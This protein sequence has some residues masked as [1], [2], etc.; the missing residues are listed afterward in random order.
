[1][2]LALVDEAVD[3]GDALVGLALVVEQDDLDLLA[4]DA[5]GGVD[6][7]E[8]VLRHLAVLQAV[9][10]DHAQRDADADHAVLL[11][12]RGL[13]DGA[14]RQRGLGAS[15]RKVF[16]IVIFGFPPC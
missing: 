6:G 5:A 13:R 14:E 2:H 4:V 3:V 10:D 7:F 8:L 9:L 16:F 1:M 12:L 15:A 11:R